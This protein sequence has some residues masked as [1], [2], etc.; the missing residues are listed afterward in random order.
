[1]DQ[2]SLLHTV[3]S[4][5]NALHQAGI[6]FAIAG[7]CA[8]YARG[9]PA[10][11]HDVD[12]FLKEQDLAAA[13]DVVVKGGMRPVEPPED[14]LTKV[15]DDDR[16]VDLIFRPNQRPVTDETLDTAEEMRI[17]PTVAPVV[18]ATDLIID[19]LLVLGPHRCDFTPLL[20][21]VRALREQADWEH[22]WAETNHSPYARAF[23]TLIE[24]LNVAET[25]QFV[26]PSDDRRKEPPWTAGAATTRSSTG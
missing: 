10:S 11:D 18:T 23:L 20:L 9:G 13:R 1:M 3:T 15:Y 12:I 2:Q 25:Q 16:L 24:E 21:I 14:W 4:V 22:V 17:G 19:K 26:A 8:V 5:A 7:G 6:R